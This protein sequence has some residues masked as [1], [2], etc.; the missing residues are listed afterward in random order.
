MYIYQGYISCVCVYKYIYQSY[1]YHIYAH[2]S[3]MY[4]HTGGEKGAVNLTF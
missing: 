2:T 1:I 4:I 3:C